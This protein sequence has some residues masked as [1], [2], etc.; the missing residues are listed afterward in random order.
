MIHLVN[1]KAISQFNAFALACL[2]CAPAIAG[3]AA[4]SVDAEFQRQS[5]LA[6]AAP[7]GPEGKPWLQFV[8]GEMLNTARYKKP[9]PY[10]LCFSNASV[11]NPWRVVGWNTMKAEVELQK[12]NIRNF[13]YADAQ[14]KDAK[15]IADI[16]S[17]INSGKCDALIVSPN[18]AAALTPV[19]EEACRKLPVVTFDRAVNTTCPVTAV[20]S[21]GGYAWGRAGAAYIAANL[22]KGGKV[23]VLRT[24]PGVEVF[25]T[26]W[27]A[28]RRVFAGAGIVPIGNEF[29]GG[30]RAKTKAVVNDY[31][32][33]VGKIDAVWVDLGA[34]SV[35]VVEA[36]EDAGVPFPIITGE[37]QQD[38]LRA[39][40]KHG[41]K[42][43]APTYPAYQW[44]SAV[45][46]ALKILKGVPVP[47]PVWTLPQPVIT[48]KDLSKYVNPKLSPLHY[49]MCGCDDMPGFPERWG[50]KQ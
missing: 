1:H 14:G 17:L 13:E 12:A 39:W 27:E 37:D 20:K 30:D 15:Q 18:T 26:R 10:N 36:F 38:Y 8:D 48:S 32:S 41:F 28:A 2:A 9:G 11:S 42:G 46:A 50:G 22:P 49:S 16:R 43:I 47:G 21:V 31:L 19:I 35:A 3:P 44:R 4:D 34:V 40:K 24:A 6:A 33:R 23:L 5:T 29:V 7:Q 25:E 45:L